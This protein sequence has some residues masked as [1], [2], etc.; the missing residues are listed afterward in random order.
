[1]RIRIANKRIGECVI[2]STKELSKPEEYT[3]KALCMLQ[4][5][6]MNSEEDPS[7]F[8][9]L[10]HILHKAIDEANKLYNGKQKDESDEYIKQL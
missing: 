5:M 9:E 6:C 4:L 10:L 8:S 2:N 3:V 7:K 1:M